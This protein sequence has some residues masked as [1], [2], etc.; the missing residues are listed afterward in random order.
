MIKIR[1]KWVSLECIILMIIAFAADLF[2]IKTLGATQS[3]TF[4]WWLIGFS[5]LDV[6]LLSDITEIPDR[7]F[8]AKKAKPC[9]LSTVCLITGL[10]TMICVI[11][12][13]I[14]N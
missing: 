10:T 12:I 1:R 6:G 14:L 11:V 2:F 8:W 3:N 9:I 7:D 13:S 5:M 4:I